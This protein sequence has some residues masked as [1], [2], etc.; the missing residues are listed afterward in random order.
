MKISPTVRMFFPFVATV[1]REA[2]IR[3][4]AVIALLDPVF[5]VFAQSVV[6]ST[7]VVVRHAEKG[8]D[9]PV[10]PKLS[11][12]GLKRAEA[13]AVALADGR[14]GS[15]ITTHLKRTQ[16]TAAPLAAR[17]GVKPT[18]LAVKRGDTAGHITDT[19]AAVNAARAE[20]QGMILVIGH[21][22]TVPLIVKALSGVPVANMCDSQH[23]DLFV[24]TL[25]VTATEPVRVVRAKY[26]DADPPVVADCR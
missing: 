3:V 15:I 2:S 26:G 18:V 22:N 19:V 6:T 20:K 9:D 13:L 10:D 24:V 4:V 12:A 16:M 1:C 23:A 14:V 7:V 25:G 17:I 8:D 11:L 21:S 5:P